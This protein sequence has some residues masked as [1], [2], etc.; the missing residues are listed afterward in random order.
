MM[1]NSLFKKNVISIDLGSFETKIVKGSKKKDKIKI[2]KAFSFKIPDSVYMNGYIKNLIVLV[3]SVRNELEKN[4]IRSGICYLSIKSADIVTREIS[5]PVVDPEEIDGLLKYQ[6]PEY[7]PMDYSKYVIQHKIIDKFIEGDKEK[8]NVLVVAT[9]VDMVDMHYNFVRDIGLRPVILDYQPNC[10]WKL[11]RFANSI[12]GK[13]N[14]NDK[15]IAAIDLGYDSIDVTI[16]R[17]GKIKIARVIDMESI[18]INNDTKNLVAATVEEIS[19]MKSDINDISILD[20]KLSDHNRYINNIRTN[21]ESILTIIDRIFKFYFSNYIGCEI[22]FIILFGGLSNINGI[23]KLFLNYFGIP[24]VILNSIEKLNIA[25]DLNK[26]MNCLG[27]LIRDD[28]V[29]YL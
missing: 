16:I 27:L 5:F 24:T 19:S 14:V 4:K 6:L 17:E 7:L 1:F 23:D 10:I 9:P 18:T 20:D 26:Y 28:G 11:F 29:Q 13:I 2:D 25:V 3:D 22:D 12:N 8:L 21:I 15:T